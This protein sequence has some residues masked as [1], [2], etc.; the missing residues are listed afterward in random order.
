V[1]VN[2]RNSAKVT[3]TSFFLFVKNRSAITHT[4]APTEISRWQKRKAA[5]LA[6]SLKQNQHDWKI[7]RISS[8]GQSYST[9]RKRNQKVNKVGH[10]RRPSIAYL[11]IQI[12][13]ASTSVIAAQQSRWIEFMM[14]YFPTGYFCK[15]FLICRPNSD[16]LLLVISSLNYAVNY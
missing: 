12:A 8:T 5:M 1:A 6:C 10:L 4:Q 7:Q 16:V 13:R 11:L 15:D 3:F 2:A 9:S 14:R